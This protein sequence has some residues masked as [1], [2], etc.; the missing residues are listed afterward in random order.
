MTPSA[1]LQLSPYAGWTASFLV[2]ASVDFLA[3]TN[4]RGEQRL[5]DWTDA[6]GLARSLTATLNSGGLQPPAGT[7][8]LSWSDGANAPLLAWISLDRI[9][10]PLAWS[11]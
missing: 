11:L 6:A 1:G 8:F 2:P 4:A 10:S 7:D 5:L 9:E 3:W